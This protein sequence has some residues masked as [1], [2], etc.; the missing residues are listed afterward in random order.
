MTF[1][2]MQDSSTSL[3]RKQDKPISTERSEYCK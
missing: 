1:V 3:I 2:K